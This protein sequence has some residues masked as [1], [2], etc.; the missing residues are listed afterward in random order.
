[1][2]LLCGYYEPLSDQPLQSPSVQL[3]AWQPCILVLRD[4]IM[5]QVCMFGDETAYSIGSLLSM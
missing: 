1:M 4:L 5:F 3:P 2:V